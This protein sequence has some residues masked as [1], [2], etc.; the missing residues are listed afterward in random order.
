MTRYE[1]WRLPAAK[2][3][4]KGFVSAAIVLDDPLKTRTSSNKWTM[5][6]RNG[7]GNIDAD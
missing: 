3:G 7:P 2:R 1:A 5:T 4:Q 6:W